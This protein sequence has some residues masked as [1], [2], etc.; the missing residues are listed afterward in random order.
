MIFSVEEDVFFV[1]ILLGYLLGVVVWDGDYI[2]IRMFVIN[3]II[4]FIYMYVE[5]LDLNL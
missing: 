2:I 1:V 5:F 4:F 3:M